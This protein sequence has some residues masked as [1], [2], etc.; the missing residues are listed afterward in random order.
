[1]ST[2]LS[3]DTD[4]SLY[5]SSLSISLYVR[6]SGLCMWKIASAGPPRSLSLCMCVYMCVCVCVY[7]SLHLSLNSGSRFRNHRSGRLS[8]IDTNCSITSP[9]SSPLQEVGSER[10]GGGKREAAHIHT[11][12][13]SISVWLSRDWSD[14]EWSILGIDLF[15]CSFYR[16]FS[17][18]RSKD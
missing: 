2:D 7:V 10:E 14:I 9:K 3:K 12:V 1:M 16:S 18:I 4:R 8:R 13:S 6:C 5:L 11:L 17:L 15:D